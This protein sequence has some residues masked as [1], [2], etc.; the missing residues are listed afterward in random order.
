MTTDRHQA[1]RDRTW[2]KL[3]S[4]SSSCSYSSSAFRTSEY[5]DDDED[6]DDDEVELVIPRLRLGVFSQIF[7]PVAVP[8]F[9]ER[10][11]LN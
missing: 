2:Q 9:R 5:E 4:S 6:D 7:P 11:A 3:Q 1:F 8:G 10:P